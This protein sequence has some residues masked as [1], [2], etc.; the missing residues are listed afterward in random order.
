MTVSSIGNDS[1][2]FFIN[3]LF[4]VEMKGVVFCG[5]PTL[6]SKRNIYIIDIHDIK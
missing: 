4:L 5:R 1:E 6:I 3:P 2:N